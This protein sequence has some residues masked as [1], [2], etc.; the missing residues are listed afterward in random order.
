MKKLLVISA[1]LSAAAV[2][3]SIAQDQGDPNPPKMEGGPPRKEI[4][5]ALNKDTGRAPPS[6]VTEATGQTSG[7]AAGTNVRPPTAT[8][9]EN[10]AARGPGAPAGA[11]GPSSVAAGAPGVEAKRGTQAGREWLPPNEIRRKKSL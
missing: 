5:P 6:A 1:L 9:K 8:Q 11:A 10:P 4:K 3:P 7:P 2:V